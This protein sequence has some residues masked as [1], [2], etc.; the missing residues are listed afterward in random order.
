MARRK[1]DGGAQLME[2]ILALFKKWPMSARLE[3]VAELLQ[4]IGQTEKT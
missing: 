2:D 1:D 3:F 4:R